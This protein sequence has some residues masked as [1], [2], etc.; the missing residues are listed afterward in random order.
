LQNFLLFSFY[1]LLH[2]VHFFGKLVQT[3][4]IRGKTLHEKC[5]CEVFFTEHLECSKTFTRRPFVK[6]KRDGAG[7]IAGLWG[8]CGHRGFVGYR[9]GPVPRF[10]SVLAMATKKIPDAVSAEDK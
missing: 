4:K 7:N 6:K 3:K 2:L 5:D 1:I 10:L 9:T 8:V